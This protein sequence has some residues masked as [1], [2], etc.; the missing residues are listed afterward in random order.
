MQQQS[1][2]RRARYQDR[3]WHLPADEDPKGNDGNH[4]CCHVVDGASCK[5]DHGS[6]DGP[7]CCGGYTSDKCIQLGIFGPTFV[8]WRKQY[9]N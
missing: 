6:G 8:G 1:S 3:L 9:H 4:Q 2:H 5:H 7:S